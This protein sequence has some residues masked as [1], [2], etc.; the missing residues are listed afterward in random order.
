M[1]TLYRLFYLGFDS[2]IHLCQAIHAL[3]K[4]QQHN[5]VEETTPSIIICNYFMNVLDRLLVVSV[6]PRSQGIDNVIMNRVSYRSNLKKHPHINMIISIHFSMAYFTD[7]Y[8]LFKKNEF[9]ND[10]VVVPSYQTM[11]RPNS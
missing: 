3:Y 2:A 6:G 9:E 10:L 11:V 8:I 7:I 5:E 4:E 1:V